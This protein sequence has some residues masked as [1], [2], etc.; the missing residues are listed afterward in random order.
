MTQN[1][2]VPIH[3]GAYVREHVLPSGMS[4]TAA[5]KILG[6]G[7]PGLSNFL[8]GKAGLSTRLARRFQEAFG[9]DAL[10]LLER[11]AEYDA[12]EEVARGE[13]PAARHYSLIGIDIRAIQID[14]WANELRAR[15]ELPALLRVLIHSTG[16]QVDHVDFPAFENVQRPGWDGRI[17]ANAATAKIPRGQSCWELSCS[18][19]PTS[20]ANE[21]WRR[22][23]RLGSLESRR[24]QTFVFATARNWPGKNA[25]VEEKLAA[26]IW[27][28]VRAYDA[29]DLEDW[30]GQS[31]PAQVW[32]AERLSLSARG[33]RSLERCWND[34]AVVTDPPLSHALFAP[35]VAHH[36]PDVER[37]LSHPPERPLVI[38][39]NSTEEGL[40]FLASLASEADQPSRLR[41]RTVVVDNPDA[42]ASLVAVAPESLV[43]VV[44]TRDGERALGSL[45]GHVHCIVICS[46]HL[47][48]SRPDLDLR[49]VP[50]ADFRSAV[51]SMGFSSNEIQRLA[52]ESGRSATVFRRRLSTVP[53]I[54][55]PVWTSESDT[56]RRMIPIALAGVWR[57][58]IEADQE[59]LGLL[60]NATYEEIEATVSD[61]VDTEDAPVWS[62]GPFRGTTSRIDAL[63][64]VGR[65]MTQPD[66]DRFLCAAEYVLS[67][68]DPA[69]E[70]EPDQR[71]AAPIY[72]KTRNHSDLLRQNIRETLVLLAV[73]GSELFPN[74]TQ[75][76]AASVADLVRRLLDPFRTDEL[77]S[78]KDDLPN[79]AEAAPSVFLDL[80]ER[81]LETAEPVVGR[82]F[83]P[84]GDPFFTAPHRIGMLG[85]L[86]V[87]A[88]TPDH[89]SRVARILAR[90]SAYPIDDNWSNTP[91]NSL[92]S[93]FRA[94][95]PQTASSFEERVASLRVIVREHPDIGW[96]LCTDQFVPWTAIGEYNHPPRWR[97]DAIGVGEGV[98]PLEASEF[99]RTAVE[100]ALG[101]PTP[102][103]EKLGTLIDQLD[104][105]PLEAQ[106]TVWHTVSEWAAT[107]SDIDKTALLPNV[108]RHLFRRSREGKSSTDEATAAAILDQLQPDD[109][110]VRNAWMFASVWSESAEFLED[111]ADPEHHEEYVKEQRRTALQTILT[112][113]GLDGILDLVRQCPGPDTVAPLL[114]DTWDGS[115]LATFILTALRTPGDEET[116]RKYDAVV[117]GLLWPPESEVVAAVVNDVYES[118]ELEERVRFYLCMPPRNETWR[119]L[120]REPHEVRREY[121][122]R[123]NPPPLMWLEPLEASEMIDRLLDAQRPTALFGVV[124][125]EWEKIETAR[126]V[127][128]LRELPNADPSHGRVSRDDIEEAF[129]ALSA[130]EEVTIDEKAELEFMY[131]DALRSSSYGI[132]SLEEK[133]ATSPEFFVEAIGLA[134]RRE[135]PGE[136]P[137]AWR[138]GDDD[139]RRRVASSAYG[140]LESITRLPTIEDEDLLT[141]IDQVRSGCASVGRRKVG[142]RR[143]G[144]LLAYLPS[145]EDGMQPCRFVCR[146]IEST[147]SPEMDS[148]FVA[149]EL[150]R[151]A[152]V[153]WGSPGE[154]DSA[155][156]AEYRDYARRRR[157]EFPRVGR[158]LDELSRCYEGRAEWWDIQ[159]DVRERVE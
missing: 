117:R 131:L 24:E 144:R 35:A 149:G 14:A 153:H 124:F 45:V 141:W 44:H 63:F 114:A 67:E 25:W 69:L 34:W 105:L 27:S 58:D 30:I 16:R 49:R 6:V 139:S 108:R 50:M 10:Q 125:Q 3:P 89:L 29:S 53:A 94:G 156:S 128:L 77:L 11:Q 33:L 15:D 115:T 61:L 64:A 23:I 133:V 140:L 40:A 65:R 134:F 150:G 96:V 88:W 155:L 20:K 60:G 73:F 55:E 28:D 46:R 91:L 127:R 66:L 146:L 121:W 74:E 104:A 52:R 68:T 92:K 138:L 99:Q 93:I 123:V 95:L 8:N 37:W 57:S 158:L 32:F 135:D 7:R 36:T 56:L 81:D 109:V 137:P 54:R 1:S 110:V 100:L 47:Y 101:W 80:I 13:A 9:V 148:G 72:G 90:L 119:R 143:I 19:D 116:K 151:R 145:D 2:D 59:I 106:E 12:Q 112:E 22:R 41:H 38:G 152:V 136:D 4:V 82:L 62:K 154:R 118:L 42:I 21:D 85:A 142:D 126:L 97:G 31:L 83:Q 17:L 39:A 78:Y 111:Y 71:W 159:E 157:D 79:L 26:G 87:L 103:R 130:R 98:S 113:R 51:E 122:G 70:L 76:V 43:L 86:E 129:V 132:P 107:A 48:G 120:K 147:R 75:D 102:G 84:A 18:Q 5:A